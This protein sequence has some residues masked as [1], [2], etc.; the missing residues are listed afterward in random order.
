MSKRGGKTRAE[1]AAAEHLTGEIIVNTDASI[2]IAPRCAQA[3]DRHLRRPRG[4]PRVGA[5]HQRRSGP[6]DRATSASRATWATRWPSGTSRRAWAGSSAP[7][8][9]STRSGRSCTG[10]PLP[11]VL[12]RDFAAALHTIEHGFRAVSVPDA[13]CYVPR[14][15]SLKKEFTRKIRTITRGME[16]LW[17]KRQ[18]LNPFRTGLYAW[19]LVQ[20]Q[21]LRWALPW[22]AVAAYAALGV[23]ASARRW[24]WRSS[25]AAR[26]PAARPRWGGPWRIA[27]R[28][29]RLLL[30]PGLPVGR[31]PRRHGGRVPRAQGRQG[32]DLG[33]HPSRPHPGPLTPGP[34]ASYPRRLRN[35]FAVSRKK[36]PGSPKRST[37]KRSPGLQG[38]RNR[39]RAPR[40]PG[41]SG[42]AARTAL[43]VLSIQM[44]WSTSPQSHRQRIPSRNV[45][46]L[47][48]RPPERRLDEEGREVDA[49]VDREL[50]RAP[51]PPVDLHQVGRAGA[52]VPLELD[53]GGAAPAEALEQPLRVRA[54]VGLHRARSRGRR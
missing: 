7:R 27:A 17:H 3:V 23:L 15:T 37:S 31:Q 6:A 47:G 52:R 54:Q 12:S 1:N 10:I 36:G 41:R 32:P 2:R 38:T 11:E 53:H 22:A 40:R 25:R 21:G 42:C 29:P 19:M 26:C 13:I 18:L 39:P 49:G 46:D 20:P 48:P 4:G 14:T 50:Q 43:G 34:T 8:G 51:E 45:P 9:A 28:V 30:D 33:A 44:R 35:Q 24:R 5:R 16:T